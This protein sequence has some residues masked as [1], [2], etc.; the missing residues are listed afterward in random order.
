QTQIR[1]LIVESH[2]LHRLGLK[3]IL[4]EQADI[5]IAG[6]AV[7]GEEGVLIHQRL[8]P[9]VT[10]YGLR[11]P[12]LCGVDAVKAI[13]ADSPKAQIII[14]ADHT[15]DNEIKRSLENGACGYVMKD[16][17][18]EE[19]LKA[20]RAVATGKR[21][22]SSE[23]AE[24]L[25]EHVGDEVLTPAELR[26]LKMITDGKSNKEIAASLDITDNTVKT[27]LKNIFGKLG[28]DDRTSAAMTA[29]RR[30]IIRADV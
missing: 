5:E 25:T 9:D 30:G 12:D 20:I 22:V 10:L 21:F 13:R 14:L 2:P 6:V 11:I 29:I 16:A 19:L 18:A 15:G 26:V 1:V 23:V 28:V 4:E 7:S 24:I 27:H 3:A 8:E 17:P